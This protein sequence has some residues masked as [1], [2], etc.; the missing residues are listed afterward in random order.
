MHLDD[1]TSAS[2]AAALALQ[3]DGRI[4][5]AGS[6]GRLLLD[7]FEIWGDADFALARYL[8]DGSLDPTFDGDGRVLTDIAPRPYT[9]W[10]NAY[11]VAIPPDGRIVAA[12][13]YYFRGRRRVALVCYQ[14]G[15]SR[16]GPGSWS[17]LD[18]PSRTLAANA[19]AVAP[20]GMILIAG[21]SLRRRVDFAVARYHPD[22]MLD[23]A[24]GR[25]GRA[26]TDFRPGERSSDDYATAMAI[27]PDGRI[28][29]VGVSDASGTRDFALARYLAD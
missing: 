20:D 16:F 26:D 19:L 13:G 14:P 29:A 22:G 28:V 3:R 23:M 4:V 10:D 12:G 24:F 27:Q 18:Q 5:A 11:A 17:V 15:G 25:R 6:S 1:P 9:S 7:E 2:V 21:L 8:P